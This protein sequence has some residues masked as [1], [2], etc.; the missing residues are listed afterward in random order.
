[1]APPILEATNGKKYLNYKSLRALIERDPQTN[2][3]VSVARGSVALY[4]DVADRVVPTEVR[5]P[6]DF[7]A[8]ASTNPADRETAE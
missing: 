8:L 5:L 4:A 2:E 6:D 3:L 1:M 7:L